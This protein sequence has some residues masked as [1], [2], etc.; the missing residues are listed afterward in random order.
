MSNPLVEYFATAFAQ[1]LPLSTPPLV[2]CLTNEISVEA[3]ANALLAINAKPVMAD[4][5]RELGAFLAQSDAALL[6]LGHLSETR[7]ASLRLASTTASQ[8]AV[9]VV[10]DLV[11]IGASPI[12]DALGHQLLG[13]DPAVVKG[14]LSEMRHLVGLKS[15]A[16]GVDNDQAD[17]DAAAL[18]ELAHHLQTISRDYPHTVFLA[19]GPTD[20]V[21]SATATWQLHNGVPQLDRFTGTGDIVGALIAAGLG[22]G[23][24]ALAATVLAVSYFNRCG[25]AADSL[26]PQAGLATFR[27][28]VLD[29]LSTLGTAA[30]WAQA[31]K[32]EEL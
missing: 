23:F 26:S 24:E 18:R 11:G 1:P 15:R 2:Q 28:A 32:G 3:V 22:A 4:D 14:N 13:D 30:N 9:P 20:L 21:V 6:N 16:R 7:E 12:R 19:T 29:Q 25:E 31:V 8:Q 17:S 10:V 27:L 5:P